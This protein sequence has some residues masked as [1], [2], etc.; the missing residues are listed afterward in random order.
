MTAIEKT[1]HA[2]QCSFHGLLL[3]RDDT[4]GVALMWGDGTCVQGCGDAGGGGMGKDESAGEG[5][6]RRWGGVWEGAR[7]DGGRRGGA[8][9]GKW[10]G[11]TS[12]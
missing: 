11:G 8:G 1:L 3:R 10:S 5:G 6:S 7:G 4:G 2:N 12:A 9:G